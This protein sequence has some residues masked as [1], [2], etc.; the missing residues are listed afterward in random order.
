MIGVEHGFDHRPA[1]KIARH[2]ADVAKQFGR[3]D[4]LIRELDAGLRGVAVL[5]L[6][7]CLLHVLVRHEEVGLTVADDQRDPIRVREIALEVK[8]AVRRRA[9]VGEVLFD[10]RIEIA[11]G[12]ARS[13]P[14][15]SPTI[16][17][18]RTPSSASTLLGAEAARQSPTALPPSPRRVCDVVT[19]SITPPS[20][21][22]YSAG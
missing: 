10:R 7:G 21:R 16:V 13:T 3:K 1:D 18:R 8:R 19:T 11:V 6:P 22:P 12:R 14:P 5:A 17:P 2:A 9:V 20:L 15:R 4:L